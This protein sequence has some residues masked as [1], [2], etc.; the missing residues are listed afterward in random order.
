MSEGS[1]PVQIAELVEQFAELL[2]RY[3]Y[4]LTGNA[5]DAEDLT[6]QTFLTAQ[7]KCDQLRD[8]NAAKGWLCSILRNAF[9]TTRR[10]RGRTQPL[11]GV[12]DSLSLQDPPDSLVDPDELQRALM[13]LPE[14]HRSPLILFYFEEFSYQEIAEQMQLP[15]G[16]VMSRLSRAKAFLRRRLSEETEV[17]GRNHREKVAL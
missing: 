13:E 9:L 1:C 17:G 14:E 15:I 12:V 3:A 7:Q 16:T 11:E 10:Q 2:Y 4:R 6:Q 5:V 8:C